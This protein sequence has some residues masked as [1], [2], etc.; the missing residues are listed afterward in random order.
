MSGEP[1]SVCH[2]DVIRLLGKT[3]L[4]IHCDNVPLPHSEKSEEASFLIQYAGCYLIPMRRLEGRQIVFTPFLSRMHSCQLQFP[5]I[6]PRVLQRFHNHR[7]FFLHR[8]H[9]GDQNKETLVAG[10]KNGTE[11]CGRNWKKQAHVGERC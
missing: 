3:A 4:C 2:S 10:R 7:S 6:L 9:Q 5:D 8:R 11:L 1:F